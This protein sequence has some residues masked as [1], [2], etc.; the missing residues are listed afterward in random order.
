MFSGFRFDEDNPYTYREGKRLIRLMGLE[1]MKNRK[2][3]KA[4]GG[5]EEGKGRPALTE[6]EDG[7]VWNII[8]RREARG[9]PFTSFPHATMVLRPADA[10]V[11]I[12]I[13]NGMKGGIKRRLLEKGRDRFA[14]MLSV[15]EANLRGILKKA[16][17]AKPMFYI[18]QRH[19]RSQ[20]SFPDTDGKIEADL[21]TILPPASGHIR[22]QPGWLDAMYSILTCKRT[23]IQAGIEVHFPYSAPRMRDPGAIG[24]LVDAWIALTPL[25]AFFQHGG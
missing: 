17:T 9:L 14:Q 11:A 20:R 24:V 2:L 16:P 10:A 19:Y 13:P 3:L 5:D 8:P 22:H 21:R 7:S 15:V 25:M 6:G 12:T 18:I 4:L 23:N 1:F